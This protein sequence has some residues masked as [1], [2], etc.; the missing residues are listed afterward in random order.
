MKKIL[1]LAV[2]FGG[3]LYA[4]DSDSSNDEQTY[5]SSSGNKYKYDLSDPSDRLDYSVDI[6]AQ[7]DDSVDPSV[8]MDRDMGEYGG[9]IIDD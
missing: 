3:M 2:M 6:G 1:I 5:E 4:Y 7:L 8:G 9:G